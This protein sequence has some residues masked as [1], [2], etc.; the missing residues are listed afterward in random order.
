MGEAVTVAF[1]PYRDVTVATGVFSIDINELNGAHALVTYEKLLAIEPSKAA[2]TC[3][4]WDVD[5][6]PFDASALSGVIATALASLDNLGTAIDDLL[7][8]LRDAALTY[9]DANSFASV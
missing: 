1:D 9:D 4:Q 8:K 5:V 3:A 2:L 7:W 6:V